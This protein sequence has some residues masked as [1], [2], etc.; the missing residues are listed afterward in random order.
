MTTAQT[1]IKYFAI[2]LAAVIIVS[3]ASG[4]YFGGAAIIG[5]FDGED[6]SI[7]EMKELSLDGSA[8][9]SLLDVEIAA[10]SMTVKTGDTLR[11]ETNNSGISCSIHR[12]TLKITEKRSGAF[13]KGSVDSV[14]IITL[15]RDLVF[16]SA[17]IET[18]AGKIVIESLSAHEFS[19]ELGAG[20]TVINSLNV[21]GDA[22]VSGGAGRLEIKNAEIGHL[23]VDHGVGELCVRARIKNGGE[24]DCGVGRVELILSGSREDYTVKAHKGLGDIKVDGISANDGQTV[25]GGSSRIDINGGIGAVEVSFE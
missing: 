20:E 19:L 10:S 6:G 5:I 24:F 13:N 18:G 9:P 8:R 22:E 7:G 16:N 23:D 2:A 3:I 1:S 17:D 25:G 11:V 12:D 15:P 4:I 14:L 21:S